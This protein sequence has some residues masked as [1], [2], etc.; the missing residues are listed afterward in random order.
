MQLDFPQSESDRRL[1]GLDPNNWPDEPFATRYDRR[2]RFLA[3]DFGFVGEGPEGIWIKIDP[4][5]ALSKFPRLY[6]IAASWHVGYGREMTHQDL[7]QVANLTWE[8]W[9]VMTDTLNR[10]ATYDR[11]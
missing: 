7:D 5:V 1:L 11:K 10:S 2:D 6:P 9:R 3:S 4:A 8:G